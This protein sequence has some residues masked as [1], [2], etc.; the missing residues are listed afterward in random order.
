MDTGRALTRPKS[1]HNIAA[2]RPQNHIL[3]PRIAQHE[4]PRIPWSN[5]AQVLRR[6]DGIRLYHNY[7]VYNVD[8]VQKTSF[9]RAEFIPRPEH[10]LLPRG[11]TVDFTVPVAD[12]SFYVDHPERDHYSLGRSYTWAWKAQPG[13][14]VLIRVCFENGEARDRLGHRLIAAINIWRAALGDRRG[15]DFFF[16][17][18]LLCPTDPA[19]RNNERDTLV[20]KILAGDTLSFATLG[21][22]TGNLDSGR[23]FIASK[24]NQWDTD[25]KNVGVIVHELGHVLGLV[26]EHQRFDAKQ[27]ISFNYANIQGYREALAVYQAQG[28]QFTEQRFQADVCTDTLE[29]NQKKYKD[30]GWIGCSYIPEANSGLSYGTAPWWW[31]KDYK[32]VGTFDWDSVM[33]YA[34]DGVMTRED[35]GREWGSNWRPSRGDVAAVKAM[36]LNI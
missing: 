11:F 20:V 33:L 32:Y 18:S 9:T 3:V 26:H 2:T 16:I 35:D 25:E 7:T 8:R 31:S 27:Y 24:P 30:V 1:T 28:P 13:C 12:V 36:Y 10:M 6:R 14:P 4:F 29:S 22:V 15:V 34:S 23:L 5:K 21:F 17:P 19:E